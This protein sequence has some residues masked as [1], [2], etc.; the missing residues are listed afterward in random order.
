MILARKVR[1]RPNK[2]Q[3][4]Q[5]ENPLEQPDGLITGHEVNKKNITSTV[6]NFYLTA[7]FVKN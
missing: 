2:E 7:S 6:V 3:E 1:I 4:H 5:L